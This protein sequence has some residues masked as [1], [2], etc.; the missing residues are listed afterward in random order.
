MFGMINEKDFK[1]SKDSGVDLTRQRFDDSELIDVHFPGSEK[2]AFLYGGQVCKVLVSKASLHDI[3]SGRK[4]CIMGKA[5]ESP[6]TLFWTFLIAGEPVMIIKKLKYYFAV[7]EYPSPDME[8]SEKVPFE[9]P[10]YCY[11]RTV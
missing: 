3:N 7:F 9:P 11:I 8:D 4:K 5:T 10:F 1:L 6:I 2:E